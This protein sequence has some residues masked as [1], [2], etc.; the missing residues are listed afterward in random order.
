MNKPPD[1]TRKALGRGLDA[2]LSSRPLSPPLRQPEAPPTQITEPPAAAP[3]IS[4]LPVGQ[5]Q[6]NP[7][8]PRR[9]FHQERL[10]ELAQSIRSNGI[11]QPIVVRKNAD[12]Y[13]LVAGER[14]WRAAQLA[15]L[16]TVP[17][18]V[19]DIP[20]DRL[21]EITLVENIQR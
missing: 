18:V 6:P 7:L 9:V 13:Q 11:V 5:I 15:E 8:Q 1:G 2:L 14:R 17:V 10:Q 4:Q 16:E 21:L 19:Q 3:P 20:D 12:H